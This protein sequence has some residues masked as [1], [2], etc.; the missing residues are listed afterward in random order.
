MPAPC[1]LEVEEPPKPK[2][3]IKTVNWPVY[4]YDDQRTRYLPTKRVRPPY[5]ASEWSFQAGKLLEFSPIVADGTLYFVDKDAPCYALDAAKGKVE[6][7]NEIGD[8]AASSPAYADGR[9]FVVSLEPGPRSACG[10]ATA[11]CS[12]SVRSR[13]AARPRPWSTGRA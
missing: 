2:E 4:G 6:W 10:P 13:A 8:L 5:D 9:V 1:K 11:R 7:R 12:G 3:I